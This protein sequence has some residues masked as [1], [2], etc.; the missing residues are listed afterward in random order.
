MKSMTASDAKES[1]G[2]MLAVAECEPVSITRNGRVVVVAMPAYSGERERR[3]D[4]TA[5]DRMLQMYSEGS[6][7]RSECRDATGLSFGEM[8]LRMG[9]LGLPLPIVRTLDRF[10][11]AQRAIY[12]EAFEAR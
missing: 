6:V 5:V 11:P 10:S 7:D 8:L 4:P 2:E 1:F 3:L 9:E 12:E